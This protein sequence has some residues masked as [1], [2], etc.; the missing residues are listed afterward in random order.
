MNPCS[1]YPVFVLFVRSL[2]ILA[3]T[4]LLRP[5]LC[6]VAALSSVADHSRS[7]LQV[8]GEWSGILGVAEKEGRAAVS[9]AQGRAGGDERL[10]GWLPGPAGSVANCSG[11]GHG[12]GGCEDARQHSTR[13]PAPAGECPTR[14]PQGPYLWRGQWSELSSA[15]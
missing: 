3:L 8:E 7:L 2:L 4:Q 9:P 10:P 6:L 5:A 15:F 11:N 12:T 14:R 1:R 13:C